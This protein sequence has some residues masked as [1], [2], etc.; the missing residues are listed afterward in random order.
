MDWRLPWKQKLDIRSMDQL[1]SWT[2]TFIRSR[3]PSPPVRTSKR[4]PSPKSRFENQSFYMIQKLFILIF[5]NFHLKHV[6]YH[7]LKAGGWQVS[8]RVVWVIFINFL[9]FLIWNIINFNVYLWKVILIEEINRRCLFSSLYPAY[10]LL[11]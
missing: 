4:S 8:P 6:F 1:S 9:D 2:C 7:I 3:W 5:A 10:S 11:L